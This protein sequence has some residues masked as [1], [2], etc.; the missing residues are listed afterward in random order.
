[1]ATRVQHIDIAKRHKQF[2]E[3]T[4][5]AVKTYPAIYKPEVYCVWIILASYYRVVHLFEA[6]FDQPG[7][8][9]PHATLTDEGN[10]DHRRNGMLKRLRFLQQRGEYDELLKEYREIRRIALHA[11]YF[12]GGS[13]S[14]YDIL[15]DLDKTREKIINGHL[16]RIEKLVATVLNTTIANLE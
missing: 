6:I 7:L 10:A 4:S 16:K 13:V 3:M 14:D 15:R 9:Q 12:P 11:K 1:M 2:V 8:V 5:L